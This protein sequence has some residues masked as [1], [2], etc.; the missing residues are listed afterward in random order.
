MARVVNDELQAALTGGCVRTEAFITLVVP[1][2]RLGRAAKEAGGGL[3]GRARVLYSLMA[4]VRRPAARSGR[5]D[6]GGRG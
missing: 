6:R 2:S 3:E 5:D 4:E 1:E